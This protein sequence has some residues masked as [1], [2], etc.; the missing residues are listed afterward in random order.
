MKNRKISLIGYSKTGSEA[1]SLIHDKARNLFYFTYSN[2][3]IL[4]IISSQPSCGFPHV[5]SK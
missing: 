2:N 5:P 4:Y 1:L 3:E